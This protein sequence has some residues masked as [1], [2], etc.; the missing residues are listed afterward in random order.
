MKKIWIR[1]LCFAL[2][3]ACLIPL[4]VFASKGE[5]AVAVWRDISAQSYF[6]MDADT[7]AVLAE[8][9]ADRTVPMASTTKIMTC[10]V[11]LEKGDLNAKVVI[12]KEAVGIEGSSVYLVA[13]EELT[14]LELIYAMMLESANDAAVAIALHVSGSVPAF[15]ESMNKKAEE[16]GM[17]GSHFVN[18]NGLQEDGHLS[19]ARDLSLLMCS[20]MKNP[21]F[22]EISGTRTKTISAP[23]GK[24]RYLSN[25]NRLLRTYDGCVA[26]KTGFTKAAGRCLVTAA[27]RDGKTLVCTTLGDPNDW[28]DHANLFDF[29]FSQYHNESI[30]EEGG[31]KLEIPVVGGTASVL[32][33]AN[34]QGATCSIREGET[35]SSYVEL[36][37]FVYAPVAMNDALGEVVY[38]LGE[39]EIARIPLCAETSV[40][41]REIPMSFW[42]KI[43]KRFCDWL[44]KW[45]K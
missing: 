23:E 6:L 17:S 36:P 8:S 22:A 26:G 11:A 33:V 35:V 32:T 24:T 20:A 41:R 7:G 15:A 19:T 29:G 44:K 40:D 38:T 4:T 39:K 21:L 18:P 5:G 31:V 13:G 45:K 12:P 3:F 37:A 10:L 42:Q 16:L 25:H 1:S 30:A 34:V 14:L 2:I 9:A 43:W 27:C 28:R